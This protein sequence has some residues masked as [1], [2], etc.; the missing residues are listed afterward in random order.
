MPRPLDLRRRL[1][2]LLLPFVLG[3]GGLASGPEAQ[4]DARLDRAEASQKSKIAK[5]WLDLARY[6]AGRDL[7]AQ[8]EQALADAR[9]LAPELRDLDDVAERVAALEGGGEVDA[10]AERRLEKARK[11]AAK[12]YD[13]LARL[14]ADENDDPRH[15][16]YLLEAVNLDPSKRRVGR[17][18]DLAKQDLLLFKSPDHPMAAFISL[19]KAWKPG[20]EWPVLVSVD[21]AGAN[22]RGN[23]RGFRNQ[24][25]SRDWITV[26]PHALSCTNELKPEK[27][28]AYTPELLAEWDSHRGQFD[29][30][31]L[32][33]ILDHLKT[34]FGAADKVAITGFSGGGN[35]CYGML[36]HHPERILLAAPACA[37][38]QPGLARDAPQAEDGGP[39]VH[40]FTGENDPHRHLTHGTTPP[41]IEEQT[42][43]AQKALADH[44]FTR[45]QR[46][47]LPGVGHSSLSKQVWEFVDEV[48]Q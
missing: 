2:V 25:G 11:D 41:G 8:A 17:L 23:A 15:T 29:V 12:G 1:V 47:M 24:R 4:A 45:V 10:D 19:P 13:K 18:A 16:L 6:L 21:G 36:L 27:Y 20:R 33:A 26:A 9:A 43:W 22:F 38:F 28:P 42:D 34:L 5:V 46:T 48:T 37:N 44:G 30:A 40:I 7:K 32:A 14:F 39:P 35:L 3:V 31:G